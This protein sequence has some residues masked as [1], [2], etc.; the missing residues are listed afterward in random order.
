MWV[1]SRQ[2]D[3]PLKRKN[4]YHNSYYQIIWANYGFSLTK[5]NMGLNLG[6]FPLLS[7]F[8][9]VTGHNSCRTSPWVRGCPSVC[10]TA[11]G[12]S[13]FQWEKP[14]ENHQKTIGSR[15]IMESKSWDL[16]HKSVSIGDDA[17]ADSTIRWRIFDS[18]SLITWIW[19]KIY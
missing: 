13:I 4:C 18:V 2:L 8:L 1:F 7:P 6:E 10:G 14:L 5:K 19:G 15:D 9:Q 16:W 12:V 11:P 17:P 3:G